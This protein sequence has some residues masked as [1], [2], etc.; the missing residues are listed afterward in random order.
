MGSWYDNLKRLR[1]P[2]YIIVRPTHDGKLEVTLQYNSPKLHNE[3]VIIDEEVSVRLKDI[4]VDVSRGERWGDWGGP[5][6]C[7]DVISITKKSHGG[8]KGV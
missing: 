7:G 6:K 5:I 1:K 8:K 3:T 4:D 2:D